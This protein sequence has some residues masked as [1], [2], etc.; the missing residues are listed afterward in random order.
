MREIGLSCAFAQNGL[1]ECLRG[2]W[3][4]AVACRVSHE[5]PAQGAYVGMGKGLV[6]HGRQPLSRERV[7]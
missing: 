1:K 7:R 2:R 6:A 3:N 5:A 4:H